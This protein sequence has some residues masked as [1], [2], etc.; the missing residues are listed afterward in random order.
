MKSFEEY[1][2]DFLEGVAATVNVDYGKPSSVRKS[3]RGV[4][5]YRKSTALIDKH[6]P[7]RLGDFAE[8][9]ESELPKV[10]LCCVVA[11]LDL[12]EHYTKEQE[13]RAL[14]IITDTMNKSDEAEKY[15]WSVWLKNR[16]EKKQ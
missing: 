7:E 2:S 3:N 9:M 8:L 4:E 13:K 10:S 12:T 5:L 11:L 14:E 15:G 16:K 6:Y 1:I